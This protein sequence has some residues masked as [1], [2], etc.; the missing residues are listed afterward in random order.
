MRYPET[1]TE[2]VTSLSLYKEIAQLS[3]QGKFDILFLADV[4]AHNNEDIAY[5]PQILLRQLL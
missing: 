4:L 1:K 2:E 5:T 3:E